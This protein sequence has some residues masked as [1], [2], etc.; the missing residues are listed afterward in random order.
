MTKNKCTAVHIAAFYGNNDLVRWLLLNG[1]DP[2]PLNCS[3][4][5]EYAMK[6]GN[7]QNIKF[8]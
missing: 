7:D 5:S 3:S 6:A 1:A 2:E 8:L 4:P